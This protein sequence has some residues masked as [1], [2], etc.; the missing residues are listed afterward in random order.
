MSSADVAAA[1]LINSTN[2][3]LQMDAQT[4]RGDS[5]GPATVPREGFASVSAVVAYG[6]SHARHDNVTFTNNPS[7]TI[8]WPFPFGVPISDYFGPRIAPTEGASTFHEGI[9]FDPGNGTPIQS[10]ADGVVREIDPYDNNGLG[11]HVIVDHLIDGK[12]VSSVYGHMQVGSIQVSQ[13]QTLKVGDIVGLVGNTGVSTGA[14]LHF[15]IHL[16]G[17]VPVDPYAWLKANAN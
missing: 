4:L 16:G 9:D 13:G 15:E 10:I 5:V 1:R 14:H 11:V 3:S 12:L 8:Q 17:S 7:G 6:F 2:D